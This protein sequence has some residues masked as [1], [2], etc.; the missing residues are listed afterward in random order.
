M[1]EKKPQ[2]LRVR[3]VNTCANEAEEEDVRRELVQWMLRVDARCQA[4]DALVKHTVNAMTADERERIR[5]INIA[6]TRAERLRVWRDYVA[7][8]Q[9]VKADVGGNK[10]QKTPRARRRS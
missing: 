2:E 7:W 3:I 5:S 9:R 1:P 4:E 8:L 10:H 6:N